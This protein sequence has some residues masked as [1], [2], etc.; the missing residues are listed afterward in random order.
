MVRAIGTEN[1][2]GEGAVIEIFQADLS[3]PEDHARFVEERR[4]TGVCMDQVAAVVSLLHRL[5]DPA[6]WREWTQ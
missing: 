4:W 2:E 1:P 3:D 6:V 5:S